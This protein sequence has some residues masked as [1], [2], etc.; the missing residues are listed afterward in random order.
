MERM[1]STVKVLRL[2]HNCVTSLLC[3]ETELFFCLSSLLTQG[4]DGGPSSPSRRRRSFRFLL[5][6]GAHVFDTN[7][8]D[9]ERT[10][11]SPFASSLFCRVLLLLLLFVEQEKKSKHHDDHNTNDDENGDDDDDNAP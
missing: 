4:T 8:K 9:E 2:V 7:K 1:T 10:L 6:C 11:S 3:T 5:F